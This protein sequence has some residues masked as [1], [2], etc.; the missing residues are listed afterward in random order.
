MMEWIRFGV[1]AVLLILAVAAFAAAMLGNYRFGYVLN[2]MH[3]AGI[4]DSLGVFL[5][6]LSLV[7]SADSGLD[8]LKLA[9]LVVFLWSTS[10]VTSHFLARIE[11]GGDSEFRSH[12][13][14]LRKKN[15]EG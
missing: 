7:I 11:M 1:T 3:A 13:R 4:G 12:L 9:L 10:P 5:V 6:V 2:R 15:K 8:M 14:D